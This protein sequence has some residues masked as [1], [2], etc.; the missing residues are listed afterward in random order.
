MALDAVRMVL[1]LL[2]TGPADAAGEDRSAVVEA[3]HLEA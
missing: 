1:D 3:E 2:V